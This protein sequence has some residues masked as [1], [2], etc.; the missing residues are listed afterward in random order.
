MLTRTRAILFGLAALFVAA[1]AFTAWKVVSTSRDEA[2]LDAEQRIAR[3]AD[4]AEASLNR[5]LLGIDLVLTGMPGLLRPAFDA[6]G[7]FSEEEAQRQLVALDELNLAIGTIELYQSD[8]SL[9]AS[10]AGVGAK[11]SVNLPPRFVEQVMG[12]LMS[13][14][15]INAPLT[16]P[17]TNERLMVA[18]RAVVLP[19]GRRVLAL[20]TTPLSFI[21]GIA[22]HSAELSGLHATLELDNGQLL[23]SVPPNDALAGRRLALPAAGTGGAPVR[24]ADRLN[25]EPALMVVR[26]AMYPTVV[27]TAGAPIEKTLATWRRDRDAVVA[28][29]G[30]FIL[31]TLIVAGMAYWHLSSLVRARIELTRSQQTLD[32][33]LSSMADGFILCDAQDR[34][35]RWNE[36]YLELF[37]WLRP[38][39]ATGVPFAALAEQAAPIMLPYAGADERAEWIEQRVA[40]HRGA[41]RTWEQD[42]GNGIVVH[43]VERRTPEGGV[44]GVYRDVSAAER[45]LG[46]AKAAAEAANEAKSQFLAAMSHEIRTPLNA[47]LG[48]NGLL[49]GTPLDSQ[50]RRYTEL[51]RSSGQMLL[52]VINDILDVSKIEAGRMTLEIVPFDPAFTLQ[53][54]VSLLSVRAQAKGLTLELLLPPDLPASLLGDPSR[55]RQVLFNLIGNAVK[56][57]EEGGVQLHVEA[58]D[59]DAGHVELDIEVQDSGIG[60]PSDVL[61]TI[62]ERFTQAD[63][64]TARRYG[65]SGLGLA[66]SREIVLLMGGDIKARSLPGR[67]S[68]FRFRISFERALLLTSPTSADTSAV[69]AGGE[70]SRRV[71]VAEDNAVNQILIEAI[72]DRMGHFCDIVGNGVEAV[73]QVQTAHYDVVLMDMQMPEM[74]GL[75]ATREIRRIEAGKS[76]LPIVAMTANAMAEDRAACL[77]AGMDD[78]VAKPID[79]ADLAAAIARACAGRAN[80]SAAAEARET[81]SSTSGAA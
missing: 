41:D 4:G 50:Q 21:A 24:A 80:T 69:A 33:A 77:A 11:P 63:S 13:Q 52:A 37:P 17:T 58:R 8:G 42:L 31:V 6:S 19:D 68:A 32:R 1:Q 43:A 28:V 78:Y 51:M 23:V 3:F 12:K 67:G 73:R 53:E 65:G 20:A 25:G 64:T 35:V 49:M 54:V 10:S 9:L 26:P 56:F 7:R 70:V 34:V 47:V 60:I 27:F 46:E 36:R 75:A 48:M 74:D 45:R 14:L 62:F 57:T 72:L 81:A 30:A 79:V 40:A 71:L 76:H 38:V 61:P 5:T 16:S 29:A 59:V 15:S 22:A 66:I 39:L 55:L 44:V 2:M 18:A